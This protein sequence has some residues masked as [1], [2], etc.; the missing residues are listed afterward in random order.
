MCED[1][2]TVESVSTD[3][4]VTFYPEF[5]PDRHHYVVHIAD[6]VTELKIYGDFR[7]GFPRFE[8]INRA[9]RRTSEPTYIGTPALRGRSPRAHGTWMTH[10]TFG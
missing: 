9:F 10:T 2:L 3:S 1:H 4:D 5:S 7:A 8:E 6:S